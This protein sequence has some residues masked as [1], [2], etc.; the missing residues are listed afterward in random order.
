M[1]DVEAITNAVRQAIKTAEAGTKLLERLAADH[2]PLGE[3]RDLYSELF[4]RTELEQLGGKTKSTRSWQRK[5]AHAYRS[6]GHRTSS[7][8]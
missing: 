7:C 8:G 5:D 2:G 6:R 1:G 3:A 4:A